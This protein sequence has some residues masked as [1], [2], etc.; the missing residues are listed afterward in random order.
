LARNAAL[1]SS[2]AATQEELAGVEQEF[3]ATS[4]QSSVA[5]RSLRRLQADLGDVWV[6]SAAALPPAGLPGWPCCG[7]VCCL[8]ATLAGRQVLHAGAAGGCSS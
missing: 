6:D 4:G 8:C 7:A 3:G 1:S 5:E 2:I